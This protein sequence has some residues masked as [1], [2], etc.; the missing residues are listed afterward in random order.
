MVTITAFCLV[1][2]L[3]I[4]L[5]AAAASIPGDCRSVQFERISGP[6]SGWEYHSSPE[7]TTRV[8]FKI[9]LRYPHHDYLQIAHEVSDPDSA[10]YGMHLS[11]EQLLQAMPDVESSATT[12]QSWL[13]SQN[14]RSSYSEGGGWVTFDM[15][16]ADAEALFDAKYAF[17][18]HNGSAPVLRT[19]SYSIPACIARDVDFVW[20]T[21]QFLVSS[22]PAKKEGQ[23]RNTRQVGPRD[24]VDCSSNPCPSYLLKR[25][26]VTYSPPDKTSGSKLAL[27]GFLGDH[28]DTQDFRSFLKSYGLRN[29]SDYQSYNFTVE[30]VSGGSID[31]TPSSA[32]VEAMLGTEYS[33]TFIN[34]LDTTYFAT[35]GRPPTWSQPGNVT[36]SDSQSENEPYLDLI[37]HLLKLDNPPQVLSMSYADDEQSVPPSYAERVCNGFGALAA[38]G[39]TVIV[40]SGDGRRSGNIADSTAAYVEG[41][42]ANSSKIPAGFYNASGRGVP[43]VALL[44]DRYPVITNG[45]TS[46]QKGT[47]ASAPFFAA[48][49]VLV[50]DIRLRQGKPAVGFINPLLYSEQG[51]ASIRDVADGISSIEGCEQGEVFVNGYQAAPGWDPAS[52]LGE[53]EFESLRALFV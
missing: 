35:G 23:G 7:N 44:G 25:Y 8:P 51:R 28:P 41:V 48:L 50:N 15:S 45:G 52:G 19:L 43:D 20:P 29:D 46:L 21:T 36:V 49:I 6:P 2:T 3:S 5:Q 40:S 22:L 18:S 13:H 17:Y 32:S 31:D 38:R 39:I 53:P 27:A 47:S 37:N 30:A 34:P 16:V 9:A 11:K 26:N 10:Q 33:S 14:M 42:L 24:I 1:L 12:V 4:S